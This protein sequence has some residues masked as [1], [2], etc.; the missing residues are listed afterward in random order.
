MKKGLIGGFTILLLLLSGCSSSKNV[1]IEVTKPLFFQKDK[2]SSFEVKITDKQKPVTDFKGTAKFSMK[3][4]DHGEY[5]ASI[6]EEEDGIYSGSIELPMAGEWEIV[7]SG[8][9]DGET[10]EKVLE[11]EVK[12]AEGTALINGEWIT[13][14]DLEFYSFINKLHIAISRKRDE[15]TY[16][17]KALEEAMAY[18]DSQ[19]KMNEDRNQLLTQIIRLRSMAFLAREK[20]HEATKAEIDSE[21]NKVKEQY[22][23]F[24][25]AKK[26][27]KEFG[28][29]KFWDIQEKQY[30][31]IVLS[32]KV[33]QDLIDKARKE[34]P[35]VND[36]EIYYLAQKEYEE[37]MV[38][39]VNS[40]DIDI[41]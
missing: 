15:E 36:Q 3:D 9:K 39:Q 7:I 14:K 38:S 31:L 5:E 11:Y 25:V 24:D 18:W 16:K 32:Q 40:M 41:F 8:E 6:R 26:L 21:L 28:D 23:Q 35:D 10:T 19:E 37:L 20:G 33:Q 29:Q 1:N 12:E 4:M 2:A 13:E 27:I 30:E 17:G 22:D 34:N